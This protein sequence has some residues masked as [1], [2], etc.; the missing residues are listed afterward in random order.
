MHLG[1]MEATEEPIVFNLFIKNVLKNDL[2]PQL[3]VHEG[4]L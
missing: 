3:F 1:N 4:R 2:H